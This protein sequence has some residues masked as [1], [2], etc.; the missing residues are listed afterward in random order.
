MSPY[1]F[2]YGLRPPLRMTLCFCAV[3]TMVFNGGTKAPPYG[4]EYSASLSSK[5]VE[6]YGRSKV[7]LRL[8]SQKFAGQTWTL[9]TTRVVIH[10]AHAASLPPEGRLAGGA[11]PS[12]TEW[13][14]QGLV[15][16]SCHKSLLRKLGF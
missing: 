4:C 14:E 13:R 15:A 5:E 7:S 6:A 3:V 10:Y 1:G 16:T 9:T 8:M 12:P 11:S 2:D